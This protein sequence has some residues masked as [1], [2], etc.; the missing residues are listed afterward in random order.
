AMSATGGEVGE[1]AAATKERMAAIRADAVEFASK[2]AALFPWDAQADLPAVQK[3]LQALAGATDHTT[4]LLVPLRQ[5]LE[6]IDVLCQKA[7]SVKE[8]LLHLDPSPEAMKTAKKARADYAAL[9]D[10]LNKVLVKV[11]IVTVPAGAT[12]RWDGTE[13]KRTTPVD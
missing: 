8:E 2:Y 6:E 11:R 9:P 7:E 4:A 10:V 5:S 13:F 1:H 12:V 3:Q